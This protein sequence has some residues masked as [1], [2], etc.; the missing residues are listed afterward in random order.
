MRGLVALDSILFVLY[1]EPRF[2]DWDFRTASDLWIVVVLAVV[3]SSADAVLPKPTTERW[4]IPTLEREPEKPFTRIAVTRPPRD[5]AFAQ[6]TEDCDT[7]LRAIFS[8]TRS[9]SLAQG[10][11]FTVCSQERTRQAYP[12]CFPAVRDQLLLLTTK[13]ILA[14]HLTLLTELGIRSRPIKEP[15]LRAVLCLEPPPG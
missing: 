2:H 11:S 12:S 5:A 6:P 9:D 15:P 7:K 4:E 3:A 13:S 10:S 14:A 1:V 8:E